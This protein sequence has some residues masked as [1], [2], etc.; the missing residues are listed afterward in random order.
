MHKF[1]HS[2]RN[3]LFSLAF[4][5]S[6]CSSLNNHVR[7][8]PTPSAV[9]ELNER[10]LWVDGY[11]VTMYSPSG[12]GPFPLIVLNHGHD[13]I[14]YP[15]S[16]EQPRWRPSLIAREFVRRGY[17]VA[18]P[19]RSGYAKSGSRPVGHFLI[20]HADVI[21][22][23]KSLRLI[24]TLDMSRVV[25]VGQSLGGA[26]TMMLAT[27]KTDIAGLKG[28]IN[29]AGA[30]GPNIPFDAV[31]RALS[32]PENVPA[33]WIY[34]DTDHAT[35]P[36]YLQVMED[37]Y[38]SNGASLRVTHISLK[39]STND[40]YMISMK[41]RFPLF[42]PDVDAFLGELGLPSVPIADLEP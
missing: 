40:H 16:W 13:G 12:T 8:L 29:F 9:E 18:V 35:S 1:T 32:R 24:P 21:D 17:A 11:H 36:T 14:S 4:I 37:A 26:V 6:G 33:L 38:L 34:G 39:K 25:I 10:L 22:V 3:A 23:L 42:M 31:L 5:L 7:E 20:Q 28:V 30:M 15:M 2:R 27:R 41:D 19:M